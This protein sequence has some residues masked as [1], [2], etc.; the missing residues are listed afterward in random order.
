MEIFNVGDRVKIKSWKRMVDEYELRSHGKYI[1]LPISGFNDSMKKLCGELATI[2]KIL[3]KDGRVRLKFDNEDKLW[4]ID[5]TYSIY[6]LEKV[7]EES[8]T[9]VTK[10]SV[11]TNGI[12]LNCKNDHLVDSLRYCINDYDQTDKLKKY[13]YGICEDIK[14]EDKEEK[15]MNKVLEL[16][17]KRK[18]EEIDKKYKEKVE[19]DYND[20][21]LVKK[22][23]ETIREFEEN[24]DM[25]YNSELN[26]GE[27]TIHQCYTSSDYKYVLNCDI[28]NS[29][30][31]IYSEEH[32]KEIKAINDLVEEVEAQLSLS[33]NLE[34]Q[35]EVLTAYGIVD[36]KSGKIK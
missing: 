32:N 2:T 30:E 29:I 18:R 9:K 6:M 21:E 20:L 24:M 28:K 23:K 25:I 35:R 33:D 14:N 34:Y 1:K 5:W 7:E 27:S 26:A 17:A 16:Y 10:I 36:K 3:D 31:D 22:Y 11:D 8:K 13:I 12:R 19:K 15:D 4:D